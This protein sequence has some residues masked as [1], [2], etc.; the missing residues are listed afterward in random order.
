MCIYTKDLLSWTVHLYT[1]GE[2]WWFFSLCFSLS[3]SLILGDT[4]LAGDRL[5][6]CGF[7]TPICF[8]GVHLLE[9]SRAGRSSLSLLCPRTRQ[10]QIY[11]VE[12]LFNARRCQMFYIHTYY[13]TVV[14][15]NIVTDNIISV[16]LT[17][18]Q[19][20][21]VSNNTACWGE[22]TRKWIKIIYFVSF[23]HFHFI[24]PIILWNMLDWEWYI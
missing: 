1:L 6:F 24:L 7:V 10:K 18:L 9:L 5:S 22:R 15:F 11:T 13:I 19:D 4:T 16:I 23:H 3:P 21:A 8:T 2:T 12:P 20:R 14:H 17:C